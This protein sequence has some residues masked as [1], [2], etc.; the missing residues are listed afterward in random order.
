MYVIKY[1]CVYVCI[2]INRRR[3]DINAKATMKIT[4]KYRK[5]ANKKDKMEL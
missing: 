2:N 5:L 3:N 1:I 4:K